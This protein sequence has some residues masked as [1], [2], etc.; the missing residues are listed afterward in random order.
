M[1]ATRL[2]QFLGRSLAEHILE[3]AQRVFGLYLLPFDHIRKHVLVALDEDARVSLPVDQL[4]VT[5]SLDT[6]HKRVYL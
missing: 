3:E 6:L 1:Q 4:L 2:V 5:I